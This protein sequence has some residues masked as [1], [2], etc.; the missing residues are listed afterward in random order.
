MFQSLPF[1]WPEVVPWSLRILVRMEYAWKWW[2]L[3]MIIMP[4]HWQI[5][6]HTQT[7]T[8]RC[9]LCCFFFWEDNSF[10]LPNLCGKPSVSYLLTSLEG[11]CKTQGNWMQMMMTEKTFIFFWETLPI[12]SN[13]VFLWHIAICVRFTVFKLIT[14]NFYFYTHSCW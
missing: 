1:C 4:T 13:F 3:V 5:Q 8:H 9:L 14:S 12:S 10:V 2:T 7:Q 11:V 6:I